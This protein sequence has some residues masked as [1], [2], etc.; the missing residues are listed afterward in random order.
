VR[1]WTVGH[2]TRSLEDFIALLRAHGIEA[3]ADV[4]H[5]PGSRRLPH[6]NR[7]ALAASLTEAGLEYRH[8]VRLGG[9]RK[10]AADSPNTAWR[11]DAFRGYADF[12]ATVEFRAGMGEILE[13]A[14][15]KPTAMMCAEAVWWRCHRSLVSDLLKSEGH[16]VLHIASPTRAEP[17]PWTT[18]ARME[19]GRLS[20]SADAAS[21]RETEAG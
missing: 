3:L 14:A 21:A 10:P 11:S 15:A 9:R 19:A 16:E 4:R 17:H 2:S 20:Y 13:L 12:M 1:I 18:A 6:F 8:I 7:D 5:Y